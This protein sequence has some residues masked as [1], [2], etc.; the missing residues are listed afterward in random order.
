MYRDCLPGGA[1]AIP[2]GIVTV[3][4]LGTMTYYGKR[5]YVGCSGCE[6]TDAYGP[7]VASA[8]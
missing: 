2:F 3:C 6:I 1:Y 5:N 8:C 7:C 4:W